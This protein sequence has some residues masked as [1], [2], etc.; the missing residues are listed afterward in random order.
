[1]DD[2][3][4]DTWTSFCGQ[5]ALKERLR[6]HIDGARKQGRALD[7]ILFAAPPGTGKTS[8]A[9]IIAQELGATFLSLT[10]PVK[11]SVI[12]DCIQECDSKFIV[13]LLDEIHSASKK[14][15]E[16]LLPLLEFGVLKNKRG[17]NIS[18]P[19]VTIIGATTEPDKLIPPLFDRF[20]IRP[21][22]DAYSD[23]EMA[24]ILSQMA[25]KLEVALSPVDALR[26]AGATAGV[27]RNAR[28]FALTARD[29]ILANGSTTVEDILN[30][31]RTD[32]NGLTHNHFNYLDVLKT[33]GGMSGLKNIQSMIRLPEQV[34][35]ELEALLLQ[36][37]LIMYNPNGRELLQLGR[38]KL[39]A[40]KDLV[41]KGQETQEL[42]EN[43]LDS[44][45][46]LTVGVG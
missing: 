46:D 2:T 28:G 3:R 40:W 17:R 45:R 31:C 8:L 25:F 22:F 43:V 6:I 42:R 12:A 36:Q 27:P 18:V 11:E 35:R 37:D 16:F 44:C 26:L 14:E 33:L 39:R 38:Q 4:V 9:S 1:M 7:H 32:E 21:S 15:Q 10:L 24:R 13:L 30:L 29:L 20:T 23:K 41:A 5:S 34:I 19:N